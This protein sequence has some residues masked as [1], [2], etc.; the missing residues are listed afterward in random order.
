MLYNTLG[1]LKA[2]RNKQIG[3]GACPGAMYVG[4]N[5]HHGS[6]YEKCARRDECDLYKAY[7]TVIKSYDVKDWIRMLT[8][9]MWRKCQ[10]YKKETT[11]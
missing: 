1:S 10:P 5:A 11:N 9:R 7:N 4:G 2:F 3:E 8:P 6:R